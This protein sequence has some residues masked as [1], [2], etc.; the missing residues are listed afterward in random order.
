VHACVVVRVGRNCPEHRMKHNSRSML[1]IFFATDK[2][3]EYSY[4]LQLRAQASKKFSCTSG[5]NSSAL[6]SF[7]T[8]RI[9]QSA[10]GR[11][12]NTFKEHITPCFLHALSRLNHV[13]Y[14]S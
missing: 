1:G 7:A 14:V 6:P 4:S 8:I 2:I 13:H 12:T 9:A 11:I 3:D 10:D 5:L